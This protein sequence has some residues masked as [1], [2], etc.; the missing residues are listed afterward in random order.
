M[1]FISFSLEKLSLPSLILIALLPLFL[2]GVEVRKG[3][4]VEAQHSP[5][6]GVEGN[7]QTLAMAPG[8]SLS[9]QVVAE[10]RIEPVS[11]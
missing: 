5:R 7:F 10:A 8:S 1:C 11:S 9:S 6:A 3:K 2:C 4:E